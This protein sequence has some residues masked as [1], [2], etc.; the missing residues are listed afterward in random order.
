M[1]SITCECEQGKHTR[2]PHFFRGGMYTLVHTLVTNT[3]QFTL[4]VSTN[5]TQKH[6]RV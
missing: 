5:E 6:K 1:D 2:F 3:I 4:H